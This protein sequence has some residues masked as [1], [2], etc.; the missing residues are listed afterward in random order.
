MAILGVGAGP[1]LTLSLLVFEDILPVTSRI[2]GLIS[3]GN[4][5]GAKTL[6]LLMGFIVER[7]PPAIFATGIP[8]GLALI[9]FA[10]LGCFKSRIKEELEKAP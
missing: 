5:V 3:L 2:A 10:A 8:T 1:L 7:H 6:P 9:V 4:V